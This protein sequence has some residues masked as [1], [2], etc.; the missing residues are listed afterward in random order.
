[1]RTVRRH[2]TAKKTVVDGFIFDSDAEAKRY[3]TLKLML[4][5]SHDRDKIR[6]LR[7]HPTLPMVI[8]N[9][10]IGIGR[11][12]LDFCYEEYADGEWRLVYEDCKSV[13]TR[14][15]KVRRSVCE[16]INGIKIRVVQT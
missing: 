5:A 4:H 2:F 8:N 12:S 13:D 3:G 7:V 11:M 14:E 1:M 16:A 6:N 15:S 9:I 10:K